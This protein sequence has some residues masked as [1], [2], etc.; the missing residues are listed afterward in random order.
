M[1]QLSDADD[2]S[3]YKGK[4]MRNSH[5]TMIWT[6]P[7]TDCYYH[8][9]QIDITEEV[10]QNFLSLSNLYLATAELML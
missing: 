5:P 9:T 2:N 4:A 6:T 3:K 10:E 7:H 8:G 1:W